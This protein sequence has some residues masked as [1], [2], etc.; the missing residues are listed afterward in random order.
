[1]DDEQHH[2][3]DSRNFE[4]IMKDELVHHGMAKNFMRLNF[5]IKVK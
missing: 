2:A 1:M 3:D 4:S 5:Q